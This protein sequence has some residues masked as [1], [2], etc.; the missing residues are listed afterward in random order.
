[1]LKVKSFAKVNLALAILGRRADGFHEIRTVFQSIDLHDELEF[2]PCSALKLECHNLPGVSERD[3]I[4]WK[5]AQALERIVSP[6]QGAQIV[7]NK[8]L[9]AGS[10]LGA[11]SGNAAAALLGLCRFWGVS[12]Q[13]QG[14]QAIAASLG[15]D[16]PFFLHGGTALGI[17]RGEEI[18]P[19]PESRPSNLV[20]IC[21]AVH[22][23]TAEAYRSLNLKLTSGAGVNR[24]QRFCGQLRNGSLPLAE[25]FNDFETSI[26]PAHPEIREAKAFLQQ[27]GALAVLMSGSGSSVFGFFNDEESALAASRC[28]IR[29]SWRAFP[30]KTLSGAQYFQQMFG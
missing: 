16:V 25:I 10:G 7:L 12:T 30:A 15:S 21:P 5:A 27:Q 26:L 13:E 18:Y 4:V 28:A 6:G 14:I 3:N 22:V 1:V 24:I 17:G 11:G 20:V 29:E 19:L 8:K 9:P 2:H 23:S